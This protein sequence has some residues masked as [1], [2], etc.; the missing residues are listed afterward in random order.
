MDTYKFNRNFVTIIKIFNKHPNM[1]LNFFNKNEAFTD[2]FKKKLSRT[3]IK[4]K[5]HFTDLDK[6]LEYYLRLL[7]IQENDSIDK[8]LLWNNKLYK[9]ITEQRFEDAAKIRDYMLKKGYKI[10]I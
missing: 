4:N 5:P 10:L 3:I 6:M 7:D 1:L 9:A 8:A 2:S